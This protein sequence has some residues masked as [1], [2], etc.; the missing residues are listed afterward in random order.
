MCGV[1]GRVMCGVDVCGVDGRV[2]CV[3]LMGGLCVWC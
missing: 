2:M 1:D 3:V